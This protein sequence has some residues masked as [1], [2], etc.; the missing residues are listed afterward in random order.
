[1]GIYSVRLLVCFLLD[2]MK[3]SLVGL[4]ISLV[5]LEFCLGD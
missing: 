2:I 3:S 4:D 1:M 5:G